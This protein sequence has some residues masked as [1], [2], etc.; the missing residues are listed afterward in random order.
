MSNPIPNNEALPV[1]ELTQVFNSRSAPYKYYWFISFLQLNVLRKEIGPIKVT[2]ILIQMICNAWYPV[3]YF[4]LNFGFGEKLNEHIVDIQRILNVPIDVS[5]LE[6]FMIL[7]TTTNPKVKKLIT[8]FGLQV[9]YRFLT[10]WIKFT[11]NRDT[12][13]RSQQFQNDCIYKITK[14]KDF[15]IEINPRWVSY[16]HLNYKI[17]LDF[18]Y[19]HLN[20]YV[21]QKNMNVPNVAM[22]LIKPIERESMGKQRKYWDLVFEDLGSINCIYTQNTLTKNNFDMEH[23]VPWSFVSHNQIWN[24]IPADASINSS[25]RNKLPSLNKYLKSFVAI[26]REAIQIVHSKSPKNEQLEDYLFLASSIPRVLDLSHDK[27]EEG[28]KNIMEPLI[29]IASNSG[30]KYWER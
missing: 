9:P 10:P 2:D 30:F 14:E 23:F 11:S 17:L 29:Q 27:L 22:K 6:L 18:A 21:Q 26:Q 7:K 24:L 28:F 25:K 13:E 20:L 16:I 5:Q 19:W 8:H 15:E 4:K 12:V 1:K 3:N